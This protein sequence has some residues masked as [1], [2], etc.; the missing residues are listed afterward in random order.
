MTEPMYVIA[1]PDAAREIDGLFPNIMV[2]KHVP[3]GTILGV[4]Q[5]M[6]EWVKKHGPFAPM[7]APFEIDLGDAPAD[8][9]CFKIV[10]F[11]TEDA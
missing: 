1:A 4:S 11:S 9:G 5:E 10:G 3:P 8:E 7:P 2:S 6:W